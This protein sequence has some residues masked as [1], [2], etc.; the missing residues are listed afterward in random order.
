[1]ASCLIVLVQTLKDNLQSKTYNIMQTLLL[2]ELQ[3]CQP[4]VKEKSGDP[5]KKIWVVRFYFSLIKVNDYNFCNTQHGI[6][7]Q[8]SRGLGTRQEEDKV[9]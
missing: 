3:T 8:S 6:K 5:W 7:V 1:M 4:L 2:K 9:Y